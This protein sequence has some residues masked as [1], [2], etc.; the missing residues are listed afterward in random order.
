VNPFF[1]FIVALAAGIP[2]I[3]MGYALKGIDSGLSGILNAT[4]PLFAVLFTIILL[5]VKAFRNQLYSLLVGFVAVV[6]LLIFS[7]QA[8]GS[9]FSLFHAFLMLGVTTS[10]ALN[11]IFVNKYYTHV[12]PLQLGFWTLAVS[13]VINGPISFIIQPDLLLQL[14][15]VSVLIP[16]FVLGCLSSGLGYV[17][18][19]LIVS[20]SGPLLA[21]MVTFLVPFVSITLGILFLNEPLHIGIAIGLPLMIVSLGLMNMHTF[22]FTSRIRNNNK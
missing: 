17:I 2:W 19:Y 14:D 15:K 10:Y 6:S 1:L 22:K 13:V 11:S 5:K 7:G 20:L 16:L 18:F 21:V 12:S 8:V 9:E 4:T 3:F